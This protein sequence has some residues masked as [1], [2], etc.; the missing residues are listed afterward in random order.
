MSSASSEWDLSPS[1]L[2]RA[3]TARLSRWF[4]DHRRPLPWR[5]SQDPWHIWLSEVMLQQTR[6]DQGLPYFLRFTARF[7]SIQAFAAAELDEVLL[8]WEGLGYYSRCRNLHK[9]ARL[10]VSEYEGSIPTTYE[11]WL[12]LPG[13]GPYTAAA[14]S[15]I[16]FGELRAVVDGNVIRVLTRLHAFDD[17]VDS[18]RAKRQIQAWAD[19]FLDHDRP[20]IHNEAVME[21]GALVCLPKNPDC[22][23]CPLQTHCRAAQLDLQTDFPVKK[24]KKPV[25]HYDIAVGIIRDAESRVYIQQRATDAMLGGLW[26]FPGGKVEP[27]E[28]PEVACHREVLEETGMQ[29]QVVAPITSIKHA[30]SHFRITMH[31]FEC[32]LLSDHVSR[33]EQPHAWIAKES[34][35]DYAFPRANRRLLDLL[36]QEPR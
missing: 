16:A 26:E 1:H 25:P 13:V 34:F 10:I 20:G 9:A 28:T 11:E 5:E 24:K 29:I 21:L 31:A 17:P 14:V 2:D 12:R 8:M 7:P 32:V 35:G 23:Q 30:Y 19:A 3:A 27:G 33:T 4:A 18:A 6:V 22:S 36:E 15:S